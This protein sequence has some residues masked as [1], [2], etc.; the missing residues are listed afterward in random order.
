MSAAADVSLTAQT[1]RARRRKLTG[2][3][4]EGLATAAA[5]LAVAV[6][7]IVLISVAKKGFPA[8]NLDFFTQNAAPF[9]ESGGGIANAI[10]GTVIIVLI[11][12]AISLPI[13]VLLAIFNTEFA[14]QRLA[15]AIRLTLNVL[16]GVPTI[17]IGVFI[18]SL[19]VVG[20]GQS[21]FAAAL[22]LAIIM[23]PLDRARN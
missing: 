18:F 14:P 10:V 13:G 12:A 22:G 7:A 21:G 11:A 3:I 1:P 4:M 20:R 17:V 5:L 8:L 16:A 6:L 19:V 9:G 15:E 2:R 23:L